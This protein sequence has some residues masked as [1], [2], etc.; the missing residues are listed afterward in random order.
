MKIA[1]VGMGLIGGSFY[2]AAQRAGHEVAG[3]GRGEELAVE[4]SDLVLLAIPPSAVAGVVDAIAPKLKGGAVVVEMANPQLPNRPPTTAMRLYPRPQ[5]SKRRFQ[6]A[7][8]PQRKI[9]KQ[10]KMSRTFLHK[11]SKTFRQ[12]FQQ[13]PQ[14]KLLYLLKVRLLNS[15]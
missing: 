5:K 9:Q 8:T 6:Q 12:S 2:K 11:T 3:F 10:H 1:V 15:I 13:S 4:D 7:A 14:T